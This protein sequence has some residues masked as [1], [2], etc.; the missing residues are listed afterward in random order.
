MPPGEYSKI[1]RSAFDDEGE[2]R[3]KDRDAFS[4]ESIP[5]WS[6]AAP[7]FGSARSVYCVTFLRPC[8]LTPSRRIF[9]TRAG[10]TLACIA[11]PLARRFAGVFC[12]KLITYVA[13][14]AFAVRLRR[15]HA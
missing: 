6:S 12:A 14:A 11:Y 15:R 5:G 2:D 13:T 1:I 4:D 7:F 10:S 3:P 9:A 8:C